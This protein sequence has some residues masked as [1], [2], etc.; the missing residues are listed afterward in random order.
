MRTR[1][2]LIGFRR[3]LDKSIWKLL[4]I[5][6]LKSNIVQLVIFIGH[7]EQFIVEYATVVLKDL[8]IIVHGLEHVS[9]KEITSIL[10]Y[11]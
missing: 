9:E 10:S 4:V 6:L 7:P 5:G 8:I 3:K 1:E 11:F 2:K